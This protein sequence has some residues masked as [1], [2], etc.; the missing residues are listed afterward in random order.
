MHRDL[1]KK[2]SRQRRTL[3][4][5]SM[6]KGEAATA[7]K[8]ELTFILL[9]TVP[10]ETSPSGGGSTS[11]SKPKKKKHPK[12]PRK[13]PTTCNLLKRAHSGGEQRSHGKKRRGRT[14]FPRKRKE[15]PPASGES[16]RKEGDKSGGGESA[17]SPYK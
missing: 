2:K 3:N 15:L 10:W 5:L 8:K 4:N 1:A 11:P 14:G 13:K 17:T 6:Q 16:E 7:R 12:T 9:A